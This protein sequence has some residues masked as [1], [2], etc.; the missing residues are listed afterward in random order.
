MK[1]LWIEDHEPVRDM[2]AVA[3]DK[4]ARARVQ[5]DLVLAHTLMEAERRLRLERFDLVI[6]E[7]TLPDSYDGD[8]TIARLANMGPHR[9]AVASA[10]PD[11]DAIVAT[12]LKC[13]CNIAADPVFKASLPYNRFIQRPEAMLDFFFEQMPQATSGGR[14]F[15]A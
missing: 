3:A 14:T 7:L 11:R 12:A 15:A 1:V 8:M 10:N 9:I 5:I 4:A 6:T 2:L 13:G